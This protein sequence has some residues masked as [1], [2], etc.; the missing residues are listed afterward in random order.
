[1]SGKCPTGK[2][3]LFSVS[4]SHIKKGHLFLVVGSSGHDYFIIV[5]LDADSSVTIDI[6]IIPS[7][8]PYSDNDDDNPE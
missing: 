5:L 3:S 7:N 4:V 1:M 6:S 2:T 8:N